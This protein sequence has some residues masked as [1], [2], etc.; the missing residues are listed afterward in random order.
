MNS[1]LLKHAPWWI[2]SMSFTF[3]LIGSATL[4]H[5]AEQSKAKKNFVTTTKTRIL[6]DETKVDPEKD[7]ISEIEPAPIPYL[8]PSDS[9]ISESLEPAVFMPD[10]KISDTNQTDDGEEFEG[11]KG[12][13]PK[14]LAHFKDPGDHIYDSIGMGYDSGIGKGGK[15]GGIHGGYIRT[16]ARGTYPRSGATKDTERVVLEGLKWLARHQ[17]KDGSWRPESYA[18]Q[19]SGA[20][21]DG[22]GYSEYT[23]GCTGLALLAFL[24]AGYHHQS[25]D[26]WL[27]PINQKQYIVG[28]IVRGGLQYL[29]DQQ[30]ENGALGQPIGEFFYNHSIGAL[31][32][33]EGYGMSK[34]AARL[35]EPA[36]R[37]I[38]YLMQHQSPAPG[39]TGFGGWRYVPDGGTTDTSAT[40]WC[41][42]AL[43]SAELCG[44]KIA[45]S[46]YDGALNW[47]RQA[48]NAKSEVGYLSRD[49]AGM[50]VWSDRL[51]NR[52]YKYHPSM[53][54]VGMLVRTF[55]E[56][57]LKD[58]VLEQSAQLL[59]RDLPRW[60]HAEKT[61]DY[62]YWYYAS[63]ALN[64]FDGP[65]SPRRDGK[66]WKAWNEELVKA[67]VPNQQKEGCNSGSWD[68]T[69]RWG[70]S[71]GRIYA[72]ALNT[73]TLE[74]YYRYENAFGR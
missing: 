10:A 8:D 23:I 6:E 18:S 47:V 12:I 40:G 29:M 54:A 68:S 43:K 67:L 41:V 28:D 53:T 45:T 16:R 9:S 61:N 46:N 14:G 70:A 60:S 19:C 5:F 7:M 15:A 32:L 22:A 36:E 72:T 49:D 3:I 35:K 63:L 42:M 24:G 4:V 44:F 2:I 50:A 71:G 65:D 25:K 30:Q 11:M 51:N 62:Y 20:L 73:L 31:A 58:P 52:E 39:G 13:D 66:L 64:Q 1:S 59:V 55:V 48:T 74:V 56:H 33:T 38:L 17:Q 57:D 21:C 26:R 37:A 34:K 69:D 27:D